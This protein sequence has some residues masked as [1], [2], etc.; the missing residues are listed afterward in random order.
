MTDLVQKLVG[1][2]GRLLDSDPEGAIA[3]ASEDDLTMAANDM[4]ADPVIREQ[5]AAVLQAR[6]A[7]SEAKA[8]GWKD[9]KDCP[10]GEVWFALS[11]GHVVMGWKHDDLMDWVSN[12]YFDDGRKDCCGDAE[13]I[14]AQPV[15][16][17]APPAQKDPT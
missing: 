1:A 12:D 9:V 4:G 15:V 10:D 2:L 17:P 11:C 16:V 8:G 3:T 6:A 13:A 7:L 14:K 5:A